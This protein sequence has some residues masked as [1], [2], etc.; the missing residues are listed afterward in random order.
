MCQELW[1]GFSAACTECV[2]APVHVTHKPTHTHTLTH[3]A[4][5]GAALYGSF[6]PSVKFLCCRGFTD[7]FAAPGLYF[8]WL[9]WTVLAR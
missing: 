4:K 8:S 1:P 2:S 9:R 5:F 6:S 7:E 3:Q